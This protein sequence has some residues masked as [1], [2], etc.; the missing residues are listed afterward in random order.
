MLKKRKP[1]TAGKTS[2]ET[3]RASRT[4]RTATKSHRQKRGNGETPII[5]TTSTRTNDLFAVTSTTMV[6]LFALVLHTL[7]HDVLRLLESLLDL[8]IVED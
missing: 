1:A 3:T 8:V 6:R 2:H 7:S 5:E 4:D